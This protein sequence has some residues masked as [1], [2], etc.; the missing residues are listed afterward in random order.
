MQR[1]PPSCAERL[2]C[3][4]KMDP[5]RWSSMTPASK[6]S[7]LCSVSCWWAP[8]YPQRLTQASHF[9]GGGRGTRLTCGASIG[10]TK[11]SAPHARHWGTLSVSCGWITVYSVYQP[12]GGGLAL[13]LGRYSRVVTRDHT[14]FGACIAT[15]RWGPLTPAARGEGRCSCRFGRG[16]LRTLSL[17]APRLGVRALCRQAFGCWT[18]G[19]DGPRPALRARGRRYVLAA[20]SLEGPARSRASRILP[21]LVARARAARARTRAP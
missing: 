12:S 3:R 21:A 6:Q 8:P 2:T 16:Y 7:V 18:A 10:P 17:L 11:A 20:S 15:D 19:S 4:P 9:W 5:P 1:S 13:A 14:R